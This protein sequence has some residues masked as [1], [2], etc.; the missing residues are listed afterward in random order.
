MAVLAPVA[1]RLRKEII[2][3]NLPA[4]SEAPGCLKNSVKSVR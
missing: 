2:Q 4:Y 1:S 3:I